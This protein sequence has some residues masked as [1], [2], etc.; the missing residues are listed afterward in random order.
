MILSFFKA[1]VQTFDP[2]HFFFFFSFSL[3]IFSSLL[4][5]VSQALNNLKHDIFKYLFSPFKLSD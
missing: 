3:S 5:L 1:I 4:G 2:D